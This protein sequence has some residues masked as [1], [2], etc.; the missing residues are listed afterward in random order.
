HP[1]QVKLAD[2]VAHA[3][4]GTFLNLLPVSGSSS[5]QSLTPFSSAAVNFGTTAANFGG[6]FGPSGLSVPT[7]SSPIVLG[8]AAFNNKFVSASGSV[9]LQIGTNVYINGSVAFSKGGIVT[10]TL[11]DGSTKQLSE[12]TVGASNVSAFF[13]VNGPYQNADGTLN[14]GAIGLNVQ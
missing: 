1:G 9:T 12:V 14:S 2:S 13:G 8:G 7:G 6:A 3:L 10:A 11:S 4:S 5:T